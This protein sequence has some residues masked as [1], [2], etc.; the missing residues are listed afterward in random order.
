MKKNMV[1]V[2]ALVLVVLMVF[3]LAATIFSALI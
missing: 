1:R 2:M 3:G